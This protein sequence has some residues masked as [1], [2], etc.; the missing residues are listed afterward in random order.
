VDVSCDRLNIHY[1]LESGQEPT[2]QVPNN[3]LG[4]KDIFQKLGPRCYV[5]EATGPYYL[6]FACLLKAGGADVRLENPL[7]IKRYIEMHMERNKSDKKDASWIFR[8]ATEQKAPIWNPPTDECL[9]CNAILASIDL[10]Y[11]QITQLSN[12]IHAFTQLPV[13][14]KE[15]IKSV[16]KIMNSILKEMT[17]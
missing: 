14:K 5:M 13:N 1:N 16:E 12:Q 6:R 9:Q 15:L 7:V 2:L 10:Y 11:R 17:K 4:H 8:Y 3:H